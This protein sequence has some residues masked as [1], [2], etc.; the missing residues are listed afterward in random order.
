M[1]IEHYSPSVIYSSPT[2]VINWMRQRGFG[3]NN[4]TQLHS[5]SG[6]L[7][8]SLAW[9]DKQ[10]HHLTT[11]QPSEEHQVQRLPRKNIISESLN[12]GMKQVFNQP[13]HNLWLNHTSLTPT[14]S[15]HTADV[16]KT[17]S[18]SEKS[19]SSCLLKCEFFIHLIFLL[20]KRKTF[21]QNT[22]YASHCPHQQCIQESHISRTH[23]DLQG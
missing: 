19:K 21:S 5:G 17:R 6:I 10:F 2:H 15:F 13:F 8:S 22:K 12:K 16:E 14:T 1:V 3:A 18:C 4:L 9:V 11:A 23:K 20:M 7:A